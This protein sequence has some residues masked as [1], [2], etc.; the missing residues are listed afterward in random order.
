MAPP[1]PR[2]NPRRDGGA[3]GADCGCS[4]KTMC[5]PAFVPR[6]PVDDKGCPLM[7]VQC[8]Q[9]LALDA[10][11]VLVTTAS[12]PMTFIPYRE[13]TP[14]S[15]WNTSVDPTTNLFAGGAGLVIQSVSIAGKNQ[16]KG[17]LHADLYAPSTD[18]GHDIHWDQFTS[19]TPLI[20]Q[21]SNPTGAT[22]NGNFVVKGAALR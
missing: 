12:L 4:G 7:T 21:V 14:H 13:F 15:L 10:D 8:Q 6:R 16:I 2:N 19:D 9:E 11:L 17:T 5:D 18:R 22:I 3:Y 20:M 1:Y